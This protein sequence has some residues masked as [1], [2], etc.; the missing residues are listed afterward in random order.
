MVWLAI[1]AVFVL[2]LGRSLREQMNATGSPMLA[3]MGALLDG[4][5]MAGLGL[6]IFGGLM[7]LALGV[8]ADSGLRLTGQ[9]LRD[10]AVTSAALAGAGLI[11][12]LA[13]N[14]VRKAARKR[15]P[16]ARPANRGGH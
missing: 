8:F 6:G 10:V 1:A 3:Y 5:A 4:L 14:A 7:A 13:G 9:S 2:L 11:V 12:L 16:S 15:P